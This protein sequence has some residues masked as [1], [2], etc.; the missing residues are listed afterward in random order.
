[1]VACRGLV[2]L[3][4]D[5]SDVCPIPEKLLIKR[6]RKIYQFFAENLSE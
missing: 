2:L 4:T 6:L 5:A 3:M 1:M